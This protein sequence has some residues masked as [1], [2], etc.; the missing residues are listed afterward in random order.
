[1]AHSVLQGPKPPEK[2]TPLTETPPDC[3]NI[4]YCPLPTPEF[5][6]LKSV[7]TPITKVLF[8]IKTWL[9][10]SLTLTHSF[11]RSLTYLFTYLLTY[12]LT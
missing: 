8:L 9:T 6:H 2:L 12:L 4:L 11:T 3:N 1:M 10:C 7:E 5:C